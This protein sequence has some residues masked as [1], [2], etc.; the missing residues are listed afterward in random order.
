MQDGAVLAC[1]SAIE[2][3]SEEEW[4]AAQQDMQ[5]RIESDRA[6]MIYQIYL[7]QLGSQAKV[8]MYNSPLLAQKNK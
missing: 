2:A 5:A 6:H 1:V 4:K 8:K 3:P 7:T